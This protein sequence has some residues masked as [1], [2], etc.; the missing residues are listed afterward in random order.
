MQ[1]AVLKW[2]SLIVSTEYK[3]RVS[4]EY[5]RRVSTEYKRRVS[6]EYKRRVS[7][8]YKRKSQLIIRG[9]GLVNPDYSKDTGTAY[10]GGIGILLACVVLF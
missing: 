6:A 4:T 1:E 8:E 5:K 3:R 9:C 7:T 10:R 2:C